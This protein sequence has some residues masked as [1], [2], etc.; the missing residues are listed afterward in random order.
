MERSEVPASA[1][2]WSESLNNR[3]SII[4]RIYIDQMKFAAYM[5]VLFIT[6]AVNKYIMSYQP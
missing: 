4:I 2:K 5:A 6:F 1:V 3:A